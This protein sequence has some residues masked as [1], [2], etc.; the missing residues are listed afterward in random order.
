VADNLGSAHVLEKLGMRPEGHLRENEYYRDRWWDTLMYAILI[1]EWE[2]HKQG[3]PVQW[4]LME[5]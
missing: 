1:D 4:K 5:E 3:H 2:M